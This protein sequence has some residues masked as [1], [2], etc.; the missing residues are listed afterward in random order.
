MKA[1]GTHFP[2]FVASD[3][4]R[5]VPFY[6]AQPI[7][8]SLLAEVACCPLEARISVGGLSKGRVDPHD[9]HRPLGYRRSDRRPA[10]SA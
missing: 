8:P 7:F 2:S 9:W 6:S 5:A 1:C 3:I 4:D 10:W